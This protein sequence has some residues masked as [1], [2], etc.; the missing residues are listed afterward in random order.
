[1]RAYIVDALR[2]SYSVISSAVLASSLNVSAK[3]VAGIVA[4]EQ[5]TLADELVTI[6]P[7][8]DNQVRPK[9]FQE[10]IEFEDV[11]KVVQ[12]LSR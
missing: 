4:A 3:E 5:W 11:L 6:T 7:N 12:T 9:K 10:T 1:V 8:E 2:K